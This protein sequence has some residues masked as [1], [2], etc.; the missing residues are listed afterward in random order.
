MSFCI[1]RAG[2][3]QWGGDRFCLG[4]LQGNVGV[5]GPIVLAVYEPD[6]CNTPEMCS[7]KDVPQDMTVLCIVSLHTTLLSQSNPPFF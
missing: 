2:S 3:W 4:P 7:P 6:P 5:S 1:T